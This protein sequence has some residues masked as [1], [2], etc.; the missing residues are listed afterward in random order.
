MAEIPVVVCHKLEVN[1]QVEFILQQ[2]VQFFRINF[3]PANAFFN[4]FADTYVE[5]AG[6]LIKEDSST[7]KRLSTGK[8][9]PISWKVLLT[10]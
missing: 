1:G 8:M 10:S 5:M 4:P 2:F 9:E 3:A 7:R 6:G